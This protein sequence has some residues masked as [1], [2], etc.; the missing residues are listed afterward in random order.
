M[1]RTYHLF[2]FRS[3]SILEKS[4]GVIGFQDDNTCSLLIYLL[5]EELGIAAV[6][7]LYPLKPKN[8]I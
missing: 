2:Q 6:D 7:R 3:I 1:S 8:P 5:P 4:T